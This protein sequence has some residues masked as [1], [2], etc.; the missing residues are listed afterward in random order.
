MT[1]PD[2]AHQVILK[3]CRRSGVPVFDTISG[4]LV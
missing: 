3:E 4:L 1:E 2:P